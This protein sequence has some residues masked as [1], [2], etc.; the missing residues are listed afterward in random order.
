MKKTMSILLGLAL[1]AIAA[2]NVLAAKPAAEPTEVYGNNLSTPAIFAE[3]VGIL[4]L[5]TGEGTGLRGAPAPY[6][7]EPFAYNGITYYLQQTQNTWQAGWANGVAG[8]EVVRADWSDNIVRQTWSETSVIRVETVLFKDLD[9]ARPLTGYDMTYLYGEGIE[10][11]WGTTGA[12]YPSALAT[13]YSICGR[14]TIQKLDGPNGNPVGTLYD[15]A[16]YQRFGVDGP[17]TAYSAEINVPGKIIYGYNWDLAKFDMASIGLPNEPKSGWYRLSFSLDP[18]AIYDL[19]DANGL[20]RSFNVPCNTTLGTLD[21]GDLLGMVVPEVV[22]YE[23]K[24][25][26]GQK[27]TLDIYVKPAKGGKK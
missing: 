26:S 25:P 23:P 24:L 4:G 6:L 1:L 20:P 18:M 16:I 10:E 15:S 22:L 17:T 21:S 2:G 11:V 9:P 12:T 5:P 13:V 19:V 3:G 14:L 8:G 27:T 7:V